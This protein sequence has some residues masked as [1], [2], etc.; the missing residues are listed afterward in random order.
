MS[1][2]EIQAIIDMTNAPDDEEDASEYVAQLQAVTV[3]SLPEE[4][5]MY[6]VDDVTEDGVRYLNVEADVDGVGSAALLLDASGL[7]QEDIHWFAL[8]NVLAG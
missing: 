5:R 4:I 6:D 2:E 8:F 7:A 3:A 1:D